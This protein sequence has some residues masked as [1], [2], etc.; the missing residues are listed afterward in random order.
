MSQPR[1]P[2]RPL[3]SVTCFK[4]GQMGHYANKVPL[5]LSLCSPYTLLNVRTFRSLSRP[6]L[7]HARS[8]PTS[9]SIP[10]QA[11][12]KCPRVAGRAAVVAAERPTPTASTT[13]PWSE[14]CA[15]HKC[16]FLSMLFMPGSPHNKQPPPFVHILLLSRRG[17][18]N[19]LTIL[20]LFL[21]SICKKGNELIINKNIFVFYMCVH[22]GAAVWMDKR[23]PWLRR[24]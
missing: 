17:S 24:C 14:S 6:S 23:G 11:G 22:G 2:P 8:V 21:F 1:G 7:P 19:P 12:T 16:C 4:C 13:W 3:E 9:A 5:S 20:F 10:R 18:K 15:H